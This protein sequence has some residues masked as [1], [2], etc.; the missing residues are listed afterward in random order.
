LTTKDASGNLPT[1]VGYG[2]ELRAPDIVSYENETV[3][4]ENE[5]VTY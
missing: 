4:Y 1:I 3:F 5:I 2:Y